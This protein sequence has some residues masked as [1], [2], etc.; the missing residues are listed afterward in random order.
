ML[1]LSKKSYWK[2]YWTTTLNWPITSRTKKY[3]IIS[4]DKRESR[5]FLFI[6]RKTLFHKVCYI[7]QKAFGFPRKWRTI[8]SSDC[9]DLV[10]IIHMT[11]LFAVNIL[12]NIRIF[13]NCI[14]ACV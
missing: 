3:V 1:Q 8:M 4:F 6:V 13:Q 9:H 11:D 14:V 2:L 7:S 10:H 12:L 5:I